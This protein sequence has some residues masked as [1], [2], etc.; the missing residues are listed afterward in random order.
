MIHKA[1]VM[2]DTPIWHADPASQGQD[3]ERDPALDPAVSNVLSAVSPDHQVVHD[4]ITGADH[5]KFLKTSPTITGKT[6]AKVLG[7]CFR[8]PEIRRWC[9][10]RRKDRRR[11][12]PRLQFIHRP[13]PAGVAASSG[14]PHPGQVNPNL[15]RDM[16]H[17]L[18]PYV[19]NIAE[20]SGDYPDSG[21]RST[22]KP[23]LVRYRWPKGVFSVLSS[24]NEAAQYFNGQAYAQAVLHEGAFA[25]DPTHSG[26]NQH[27]YDAATLRALVDVGTHNAFQANEDNGYHQGVSEYQSKK[28]AYETGLQGL[29]AAG[30]FVPGSAASLVLP[31]ASWARTW[32]MASSGQRR[33]RRPKIRYSPCLWAWPTRRSS[34]PCS[35]RD[36]PSPGCRPVTSST[37]TTTNGRIAT[38]E[39]LEPQG[40]T[41]VNTA[42]SLVPLCRSRSNPGHPARACPRIRRW[43][44]AT[45]ISSVSRTPIR[46]GSDANRS[47]LRSLAAFWRLLCCWSAD[48]VRVGA[49]V[50]FGQYVCG[51]TGGL[52]CGAG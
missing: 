25:A 44:A 10:G 43:S 50:R 14:E 2:M 7:R 49:R 47:E 24:D 19:N 48:A 27:L 30:G 12:R 32:K 29:T 23:C 39:E 26:Y 18:G 9:K 35:E 5:D 20:T 13:Q 52:A 41:P 11:H 51:A 45:T 34:T 8:G 4:T 38:L 16:A 28:S 37:T 33:P 1:L 40:V 21:N 6:T 17:G 15:V 31:S 36:I 42:T 22:V 46:A 3:V